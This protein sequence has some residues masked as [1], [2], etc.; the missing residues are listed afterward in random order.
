[1]RVLVSTS[2]FGKIEINDN[3]IINFNDGILG[4]E[5]E[6]K[7]CIV[8][9]NDQTL[10]IWLQSITTPEL[11]FPMIEPQIFKADYQANLLPADL[12]SVQLETQT[13]A[14]IYN[15]LT[16]PADISEMSAN[17]KAPIVINSQNNLGKQ[18]VL[19]DNKLEVK[20]SMYKELKTAILNFKQSDD[21]L[22]T[23][24]RP[25]EESNETTAQPQVRM[26][27]LTPNAV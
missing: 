20:F 3:D 19:Q 9:P 22:R 6:N 10:I 14:Y 27:T 5:N 11:A 13:Q 23:S 17:L 2:R 15:I 7:F 26:V 21:S 8:D 16:I 24:Y 12:S 18:I 4:F 25:S 1:M